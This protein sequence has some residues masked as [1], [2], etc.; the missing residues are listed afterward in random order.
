MNDETYEFC[1]T[2][3]AENAELKMKLLGR[4][5]AKM[6][7]PASMVVGTSGAAIIASE[8]AARI[9]HLRDLKNPIK[10]GEEFIVSGD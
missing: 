10:K 2:M 5:V 6:I 1:K 8:V 4:D 3:I 7:Y 9:G